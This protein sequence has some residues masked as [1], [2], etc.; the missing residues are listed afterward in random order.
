MVESRAGNED[1]FHEKF[2]NERQERKKKGQ[3]NEGRVH[4]KIEET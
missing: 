1:Y 4:F 2:C 3:E